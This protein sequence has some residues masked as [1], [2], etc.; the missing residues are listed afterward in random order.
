IPMN[1]LTAIIAVP[2]FLLIWIFEVHLR[3]VSKAIGAAPPM[4]KFLVDTSVVV[5][6]L[7]MISCWFWLFGFALGKTD[8]IFSE[9]KAPGEYP[10]CVGL[11]GAECLLAIFQMLTSILTF[12]QM[13]NVRSVALVSRRGDSDMS[14][15][16]TISINNNTVPVA[17]RT[18][19][20]MYSPNLVSSKIAAVAPESA[21]SPLH[22][23][24]PL[25]SQTS[26]QFVKS[27]FNRVGSPRGSELPAP[28]KS[29]VARSS[30]ELHGFMLFQS[31]LTVIGSAF[32]IFM[33]VL[34]FILNIP[35][36]SIIACV[37]C[38]LMYITY[39]MRR[40]LLML[41]YC[42]KDRDW[43]PHWRKLLRHNDK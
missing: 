5:S 6:S 37:F 38:V 30:V 40:V 35:A 7:Q 26:S 29:K 15:P 22:Q 33:F 27:G 10:N 36:L 9:A 41:K 42:R 1:Y 12:V 4:V 11:V 3:W 23:H 14:E 31:F 39:A 25:L 13:L 21:A 20:S 24:V 16:E 18:E 34:Q 2:L 28:K 19:R 8:S 17:G 32:A 43:K